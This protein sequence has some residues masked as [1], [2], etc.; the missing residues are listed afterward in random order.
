MP[1]VRGGFS[2]RKKSLREKSYQSVRKVLGTPFN[3][4]ELQEGKRT[5]TKKEGGKKCNAQYDGKQ[6]SEF[7]NNLST[8]NQFCKTELTTCA[9]VG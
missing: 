2:L 6:F 4:R 3:G 8:K 5:I 7:S 9:R 1:R